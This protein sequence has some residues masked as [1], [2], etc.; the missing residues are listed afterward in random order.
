MEEL[1]RCEGVSLFQLHNKITPAIKKTTRVL[2]IY[3]I[4]SP[5]CI[6]F[7]EFAEAGSETW[8]HFLQYWLLIEVSH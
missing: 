2:N 1:L 3:T 8:D 5:T 4:V 7:L 6:C